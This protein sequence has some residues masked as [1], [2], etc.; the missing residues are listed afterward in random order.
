MLLAWTKRYLMNVN[1]VLQPSYRGVDSDKDEFTAEKV[2]LESLPDP[3]HC[4]ALFENYLWLSKE[5]DVPCHWALGMRQP[6]TQLQWHQFVGG[7]PWWS[8]G[9]RKQAPHRGELLVSERPSHR[10][11][12]V[13]LSQAAVIEQ[14]DERAC[15]RWKDIPS[16]NQRQ[17]PAILKNLFVRAGALVAWIWD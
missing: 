4:L 17:Y 2:I 9:S 12:P 16:T 14:I 3:F 15:N 6:P 5:Q 10:L 13:D 11:C 7:I 8:L 1:I